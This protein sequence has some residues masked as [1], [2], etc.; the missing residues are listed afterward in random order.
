MATM[1]EKIKGINMV[2]SMIFPITTKISTQARFLDMN[3]VDNSAGD[4][5]T[6]PCQRA[7]KRY[8]I[9]VRGVMNK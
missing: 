2:S 7:V 5:I 4:V 1:Q 8:H 3:S 6:L 9:R